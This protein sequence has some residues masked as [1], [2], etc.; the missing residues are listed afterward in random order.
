MRS[1]VRYVPAILGALALC[2]TL[3]ACGGSEESSGG[4]DAPAKAAKLPDFQKGPVTLTV[5]DPW[6]CGALGDVLTKSQEEMDKRFEQK[7]P[8]V[9]VKRVQLPFDR[10]PAKLRTAVASKKGPDIFEVTPGP[11]VFE[12]SRGYKDLTGWVDKEMKD[13]LLFWDAVS[14]GGKIYGLPHGAVP[15]Q[16]HYNKALFEKAGITEPPATWDDLLAAC[17]KIKASGAYPIFGTWKDGYLATYFADLFAADLLTEEELAKVASG[18]MSIDN[19][20]T[21]E[22]WN[23]LLELQKRGCFNKDA[24]SIE[25]AAPQVDYF[26]TGKAAI[27]WWWDVQDFRKNKKEL[28]KVKPEDLSGFLTPALPD[29]PYKDGYLYLAPN[30]GWSMAQWT[31]APREAWEWMKFTTGA[32]SQEY[33]WTNGGQ[34]PNNRAVKAT[35]DYPAQSVVLDALRDKPAHMGPFAQGGGIRTT[36]ANDLMVK[37][38]A[39]VMAGRTKPKDMLEQI[40]AVNEPRG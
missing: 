22:A 32:E 30:L 35:S 10:Y 9:T 21:E 36:E 40:A 13:Q 31:K 38:A 17:D 25:Q 27:R 18:E 37:L 7:F 33:S 12:F 28:G 24:Q 34:V 26:K 29:S 20:K 3:A 16:W 5:W 14:V 15:Y 11:Q 23:R 6:C 2:L 8:N 4:A 39:E 1:R 19:P